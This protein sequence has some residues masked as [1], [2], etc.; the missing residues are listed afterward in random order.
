[1]VN[2]D[3]YYYAV[4]GGAIIAIATS[5]NLILKGRISGISGILYGAITL[6]GFF[7]KINFI[8]GLLLSYSYF[9]TFIKRDFFE[10]PEVFLNGLS[11]A[12]FF[13]SGLLVGFGTK[14]G[15]GCT[16]VWVT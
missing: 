12:G 16:S 7:W 9:Y 6:N 2:T 5:I 13:V 15:N 11:L 8:L 1:M 10:T 14:L 3:E 4:G